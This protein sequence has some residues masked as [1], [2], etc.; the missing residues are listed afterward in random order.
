MVACALA[1]LEPACLAAELPALSLALQKSLSCFCALQAAGWKLLMACALA[2][3]AVAHTAAAQAAAAQA[4]APAVAPAP[5]AANGL[6]PT[7]VLQ[8]TPVDFAMPGM[9]QPPRPAPAPELPPEVRALAAQGIQALF[10]SLAARIGGA[11]GRKLQVCI[12]TTTLSRRNS[13][14]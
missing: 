8:P 11:S 13:F 5:I 14:F 3:L 6:L 7:M 12:L 9:P 4:T 10:N 2:A 1:A